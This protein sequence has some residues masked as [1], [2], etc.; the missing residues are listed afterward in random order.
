MI[1]S[2]DIPG[3]KEAWSGGTVDV[4]GLLCMCNQY[5]RL[6]NNYTLLQLFVSQLCSIFYSSYA[7]L[8]FTFIVS[9]MY[10]QFTR[11]WV[12]AAVDICVKQPGLFILEHF[13][14]V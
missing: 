5:E 4:R 8:W 14:V 9:R 6:K 10:C 2:T 3:Y 13:I 12:G 1:L 11:G 7:R